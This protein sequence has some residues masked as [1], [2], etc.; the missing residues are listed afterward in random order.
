MVAAMRARGDPSD[1]VGPAEWVV[2]VD[3]NEMRLVSGDP[4]S[5]ECRGIIGHE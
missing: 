1:W 5:V 2:L 3:F 4:R